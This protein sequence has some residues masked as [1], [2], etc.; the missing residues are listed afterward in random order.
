MDLPILFLFIVSY[1]CLD[2][3]IYSTPSLDPPTRQARLITYL[4]VV[5]HFAY[6]EH[7]YIYIHYTLVIA[8]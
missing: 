5:I 4:A 1:I 7:D 6:K 3:C 8:V 2:K